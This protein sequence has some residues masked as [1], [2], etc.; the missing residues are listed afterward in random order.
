MVCLTQK[1]DHPPK[2]WGL[3]PV[4]NPTGIRG[5]QTPAQQGARPP[6]VGA[7]PPTSGPAP[8]EMTGGGP[9]TPLLILAEVLLLFVLLAQ[10]RGAEV[11]RALWTSL[12]V[13][14]NSGGTT[15][16]PSSN[17]TPPQTLAEPPT[18]WSN[19]KMQQ[20]VHSTMVGG[21]LEAGGF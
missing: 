14:P 12:P 21:L 9:S 2:D 5:I 16:V 3:P 1:L 20:E 11:P 10:R 8:S 18:N 7:L 4:I 15:H 19:W 6:C 17:K 13:T